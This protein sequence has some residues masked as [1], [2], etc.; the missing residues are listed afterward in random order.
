MF[1]NKCIIL[2]IV[3]VLACPLMA[4]EDEKVVREILLARFK[5]L[6]NL[7]V[8]YKVTTEFSGISPQ[9]AI[10]VREEG[11]GFRVYNTGTR[12]ANKE[13]S[14][15]GKRTFYDQYLDS[16]DRKI[17]QPNLPKIPFMERK[18]SVFN[19]DK[20]ETLFVYKDGNHPQG[21]ISDRKT[22]P[23]GDID[24]ALGLRIFRQHDLLMDK[25]IKEMT[26][27]QPSVDQVIL[28]DVD[29]K[30]ITNELIFDRKLGYSLIC[31]RRRVPPENKVNVEFVMKEFK[32][33]DGIMLPFK[34]RSSWRTWKNGQ[35][36]TVRIDTIEVS[37]Y[38]LNDPT[39]TP[40]RYHIKWP[41]ATRIID[42]RS[43]ISL[44]TK[45]G[46]IA[47]IDDYDIFEVAMD[48]MLKEVM[49]ERNSS[50]PSHETDE[51]DEDMKAVE[52][53]PANLPVGD[54][55]PPKE[56]QKLSSQFW[57]WAGVFALSVFVISLFVYRKHKANP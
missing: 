56:H 57:K 14:I 44:I 40:D 16:W 30:G 6:Q 36:K 27:R 47:S 10:V 55:V 20:T 7:I 43:G 52:D 17:K 28:I 29:A 2:K 18:V 32:N 3:L 12:I 39:N 11:H 33:I 15:L 54:I 35:E 41:E 4:Q 25:L 49:N 5:R 50:A 26:I 42:A 13:F 31:F 51:Q 37:E 22:L 8:N 24:I 48:D 38:R 9:A 34:I 21:E 1:K 19:P 23:E 46:S 53:K 45:E